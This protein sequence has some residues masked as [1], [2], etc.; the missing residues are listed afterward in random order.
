VL[1]SPSVGLDIV[2]SNICRLDCYATKKLT[3][4][5]VVWWCSKKKINQVLFVFCFFAEIFG[6]LEV[7]CG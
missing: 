1:K 3:N 5:I 2:N 4:L 7:S 6:S